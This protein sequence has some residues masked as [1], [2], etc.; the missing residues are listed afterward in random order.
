MKRIIISF[1]TGLFFLPVFA[2]GD[3]IVKQLTLDDVL[4]LAK[5]QSLQSLLARHTFL[6]S[7]WEYRTYQ[8]KLLPRLTLSSTIPSLNRT[9]ES[10]IWE[11]GTEHFVSRSYMNTSADLQLSQNVGLTGGR[12]FMSSGLQRNDN[13]GDNPY[14][15]Y[16]ANPVS[17]GFSQPINGYNSLK[18]DKKIE[19]L[20]YEEAK[21][22]YINSVENVYQRAVGYFF[23]LVLAQI[24]LEIAKKNYANT[25]TL[26]QIAKG[27][28]QLGTIAENEL[29]QMELSFLNSGAALNSSTIDLELRKSRLRSYL[30]FNEKVSIEL[31]LPHDIPD[32]TLDYTITLAEA[33]KNNPEILQMQRQLIEAERNVA[34]ARSQKGLQANLYASFG[35]SQT[36]P[37]VYL[38]YQNLLDQQQV[39]VGLQVPIL[40]W[41]QGRG[42]LKMA[43]SAQEVTRTDVKQ[44]QI[45]FDENVFLQ[46]MQFNLQDDQVKIAAKAD[47]I[48]DFRYEVSKQ[49]FLIGKIDVLDL[50]VALEE[51]DVARR[52]Y[53]QALRN[54]WSYYYNIRGMTLYN[55][56]DR[57]PLTEDFEVLM[58]D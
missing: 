47:T 31:L 41:G 8:A 51:K 25:D 30:G 20:K 15:S 12:I 55:W 42:Q 13:Y 46:V 14:T 17:V 57:L 38:A 37:D 54:Y 50:N 24:N 43:Q 36:D 40:D 11:D 52:G 6:G 28:Y 5:E 56:V 34:E 18:W 53:I 16:K 23:D 22:T 2:Q 7:Y 35:L 19:P 39:Q 44:A 4:Y 10:V 26:F 49:R 33:K 29:L 32:L 48:A 58:E 21:K 3:L 1:L 9:M 45:D 27:R